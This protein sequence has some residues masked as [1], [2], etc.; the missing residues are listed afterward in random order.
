[1]SLT[2]EP[3]FFGLSIALYLLVRWYL[4]FT[5]DLHVSRLVSLFFS[6]WLIY[7]AMLAKTGFLLQHT[8]D[9]PPGIAAIL[10]PMIAFLIWV[11]RSKKIMPATAKFSV[12]VIA[13]FQFFRVF[14][15]FAIY[16]LSEAGLIPE[17]MTWNG[18]NF[19]IGVALTAPIIWW[20]LK[21]GGEQNRKIA[22]YWNW[23]GVTTLLIVVVHGILTVPSRFRVD[24]LG[25]E[26]TA[27][28]MYP[29]VWIP[30]F[31]VLIAAASHIWMLRKLAK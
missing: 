30:S 17:V 1:M 5:L 24:Q 14:V 23:A 3:Y 2:L 26:N 12:A 13:G 9:L 20:L 11:G 28:L 6:L 25:S 27:V 29:Y 21:V 7:T 22:V 8:Q 19:E 10:F 4:R 15:E 31:F 18:R 16:R